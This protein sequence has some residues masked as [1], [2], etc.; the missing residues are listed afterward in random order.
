MDDLYGPRGRYFR[1]DSHRVAH[2]AACEYPQARGSSGSGSSTTHRRP[3]IESFRSQSSMQ[4]E[5][6]LAAAASEHVAVVD[7]WSVI[8]DAVKGDERQL[9]KF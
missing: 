6:V 3:V 1:R 9:D 7:V 2:A 5:A 4:T 8:Y